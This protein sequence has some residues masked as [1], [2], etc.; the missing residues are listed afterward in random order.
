VHSQDRPP[1]EILPETVQPLAARGCD[2]ALV[3]RGS[4]DAADATAAAARAAGVKAAV[5]RADATNETEIIAAV[6]ETV[7][8]LGRL[9]IL[10]NMASIYQKTP[11]PNG[12]AW[13]AS[14]DTN[15]KSAFLFSIHA[16]S[17]MKQGGGG[18]IINFSDWLPA[19]GRPHY[20]GYTPYLCIESFSCGIDADP[21]AG[22]RAQNPGQCDGARA[23]S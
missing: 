13:S 9:D 18:R 14:L 20:K 11:S 22:V 15:A 21:G 7:K 1:S 12:A 4:R 23:D 19:T 17:T 10:I 2:L 16:A 6:S 5:L 8:S 3:Y